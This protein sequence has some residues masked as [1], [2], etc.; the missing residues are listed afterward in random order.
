MKK[1]FSSLLLIG[2]LMCFFVVEPVNAHGV[3]FANRLDQTQLVLGEGYKD[4][5]YAPA[6]VK[7]LYGYDA[8]YDHINL[9]A[10]NHKNYITIKPEKNLSVAVVFFDYGYW[11]NGTDGKWHNAPMNMVKGATIGTHAIKYSVNYLKSVNNPQPIN[12]IP[13]QI[14][15]LKDPTKL[16]VGDQL[17]IQVLYNGKPYSYAEI[18]PDVI[19]HHTVTMKTD[20]DGKAVLPVANGSINVIGIEKAFPYKNK[21]EKATQDKIFSSLSFTIYPAEN[22]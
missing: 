10:V 7:K 15:P 18:I 2:F 14:V 21:N 1:I 20:K 8:N 9:Q 5:A 13:L 17:P 16:N 6:M 12:N 4:N 22:D 3:W 11:S 19:N